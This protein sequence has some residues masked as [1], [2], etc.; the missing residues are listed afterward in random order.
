ML[1]KF[2]TLPKKRKNLRLQPEM[3]REITDSVLEKIG[4]LVSDKDEY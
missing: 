2:G 3:A 1:Q 4:S